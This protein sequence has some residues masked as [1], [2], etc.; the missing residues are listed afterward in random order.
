[1]LD[2]R[3][4]FPG[5][6]AGSWEGLRLPLIKAWTKPRDLRFR[7]RAQMPTNSSPIS[8]LGVLGG[9]LLEDFPRRT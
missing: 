2:C 6:E 4:T 7:V 5:F 3:S 9:G 1:M 8:R